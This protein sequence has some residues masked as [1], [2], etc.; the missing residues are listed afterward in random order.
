MGGPVTHPLDPILRTPQWIIVKLIPLANG[1]A[2]KLPVDYR[3]GQV[4]VKGSDGAHDPAIW[5]AYGAA[6]AFAQQMGPN[7]TVG[8]VIT[9]A[10]PFWCL[11]ID[12]ALQPDNTWSPLAQQLC[13]ALPGT[14]VEVSQS[15]RGLH[16]WGQGPVPE[17]AAKNV[18]LGIE[19]YSKLRFIAIGAHATGDMSAPC[20]AIAAVAATYFPPR[21]RHE[22]P[23]DGPRADW[24][25]PEDDDELLRRAMQS[26]SA[27]S[28]FGGGAKAT[29]ADLFHA[30]A[31][32]LA[33]AYPADSSSSDPYDRSSADAALAQH[34]AFWTGADVARIERLM[35]RSKLVREKWDRE[36]Y[37]V[38]RTITNAC[39][40]QREVL[41]DKP[42]PESPLGAPPA[43]PAD[44][45]PGRTVAPDSAA[46]AA[47]T[48]PTADTAAMSKRDARSFLGPEDQSKLFAGCVY[49]ADYH[50]VMCPGGRLLNP[51]TFRAVFGGH[52]FAMDAR[53]E[54]VSRNAFEA[55]TESQVLRAPIVD[56]TCFK[57][58]LPYGAIVESE[59]R[60]RANIWWPANVRRIKGDAGP[61]LQH[62]ARVL[63]DP[64]DQKIL[65][66]YMAG[67]VQFVGHKFQWFP[68]LIGTEG[69]GKSLFS[70]CVAAAVGQRYTHWPA[71]DKLG[72]QFNAWLFGKVFYAIEDLAIGD[73]HEVW[74]KLK[75]LV[76]GDNIEV[77]SKG[78]D[79]R[80]DEI[81]GNFMA[82][83]NHKNA[84][85]AT[86]NDRRVSHLWMAQQ[87][88]ADLLRD[89]M[90]G[91]YMR[92]IYDWLKL[93]DGYA[94]VAELL[95]TLPIPAEYGL[96][97]LLGRAPKTSSSEAAVSAG[98]GK[99]EQQILE[100]IEQDE[101]GFR[102][103]WIS[104]VFLDRLLER[105]NRGSAVPLNMR[106]DMLRA[107]G[108]DWHPALPDGRVHNPV[109]PDGAKPKLFIK[110]GHAALA[111]T[112]GGDVARAYAEAQGAA[113]TP[114]ARK[115]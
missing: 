87:R 6:V 65:L 18:P 111:L 45:E 7:H 35:R 74:E 12:G 105:L 17:H 67:C 78:V 47:P 42:G 64:E 109:M 96:Q 92:R 98:L 59:G 60:K 88:V 113:I 66:Y 55:F 30:D 90:G 49:V 107:L 26:R 101:V 27:A 84:V 63:P 3:T 114:G 34:L 29:F 37:L 85:R 44:P 81:C 89:G 69:N 28:V 23:N 24:R 91:D 71:A 1:K 20:L 108:Y 62:L 16:I 48:A 43:P 58:A 106:R 32:V 76:T 9:A 93:E 94:I 38:E 21:E 86:A 25:G 19:L 75:P 73:A 50:K 80:T 14:A 103:G 52:S 33:A 51:N 41:Q 68:L 56:G 2:D 70:R 22:T 112:S 99:I 57:P 102:G 82:N 100:A 36:D 95:H 104:S 115:P 40:M 10:D 54:R 11:D 83:S 53:N 46:Y 61:F 110:A 13:A 79:Q 4:T 8:F 77:E 72:K 15:G 39:R 97:W 31:A 5:L